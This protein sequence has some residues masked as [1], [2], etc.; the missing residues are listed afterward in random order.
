MM[1][2]FTVSEPVARKLKALGFPQDTYFQLVNGEVWDQ[3]MQSDYEIPRTTPPRDTWL[4]AYTA[5]EL[6]PFLI[7]AEKQMGGKLMNDK[8]VKHLVGIAEFKDEAA[9]RAKLLIYLIENKLI[10]L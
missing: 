5:P 4:A 10:A 1:K 6:G 2:G 3:T 9:N 8:M 7:K